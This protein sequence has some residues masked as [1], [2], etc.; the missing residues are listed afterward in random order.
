MND[1]AFKYYEALTNEKFKTVEKRQDHIEAT[2]ENIKGELSNIKQ[3]VV[4]FSSF[5]SAGMGLIGFIFPYVL[6]WIKK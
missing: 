5:I 3:K 4:V 2:L 1:E 6:E